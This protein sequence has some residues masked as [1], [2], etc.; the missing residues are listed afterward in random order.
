MI[1]FGK[2]WPANK[3]FENDDE[4]VDFAL[5]YWPTACEVTVNVRSTEKRFAASQGIYKFEL[6]SDTK[7]F[8][9]YRCG[10]YNICSVQLKVP[11]SV[12]KGETRAIQA[13]EHIHNKI[14][15]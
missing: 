1:S 11:L 8:R 6:V 4:L 14:N 15:I 9:T 3:T 13:G 12:T 7:S 2:N 10:K 5:E